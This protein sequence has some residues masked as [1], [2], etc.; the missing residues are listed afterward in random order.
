MRIVVCDEEAFIRDVVEAVVVTTGHE[1]V[2]VADSTATAIGLIE[3]ARPDAIVVDLWLGFNSDYDIIQTALDVGARP[4]VF[5]THGDD[6]L[7][8]Y[9]V[10]L[11]FVTKP[12]IAALEQVLS[13]LDVGDKTRHVVDRERR[14][15]PTRTAAGPPSSGIDDAR[16]FFEAVNEAEDGDGLVSIHLWQGADAV[17]AE[18][19]HLLREGD[20]ILALPTAVRLYLPGGGEE[21][22]ESVVQRVADNCVAT[23]ERTVATVVVEAGE[24][25]ADAFD[26]LKYHSEVR[27]L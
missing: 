23:Q 15:R 5:S 14:G 12:D 3:T 10:P 27:W 20:R 17:A 13:R 9:S 26:R 4:I 7:A 19:S 22:V 18:A 21:G 6:E 2:G 8:A 11:A 25:G 1:V 24:R 16:A